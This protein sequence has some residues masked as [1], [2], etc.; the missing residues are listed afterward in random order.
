MLSQYKPFKADLRSNSVITVAALLVSC[1]L[2]HCLFVAALLYWLAPSFPDL[3]SKDH[4]D[5]NVRMYHAIAFPE[6]GKVFVAFL[7]VWDAEPTMPFIY[8]ALMLSVQFSSLQC[9]S[10]NHFVSVFKPF[11]VAIV[12]RTLCRLCF[13]SINHTLALGIII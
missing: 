8:A 6:L 1:S 3:H 4:F 12:L 2:E 13:H 9:I 11:V 5:S 7:Q 10:S